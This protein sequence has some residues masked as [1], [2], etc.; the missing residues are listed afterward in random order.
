MRNNNLASLLGVWE[1]VS[2]IKE[3]L[4]PE[5]ENFMESKMADRQPSKEERMVTYGF[6]FCLGAMFGGLFCMVAS[7]VERW[8]AQQPQVERGN[9]SMKTEWHSY[10]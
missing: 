3:G 10:D 2:N 1:N 4:R 8:I 6:M 5:A 9:V 7:D